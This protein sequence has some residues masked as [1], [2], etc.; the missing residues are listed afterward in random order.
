MA[1][2]RGEGER[3]EWWTAI[4][5]CTT[6]TCGTIKTEHKKEQ[7]GRESGRQGMK[8]GYIAVKRNVGFARIIPPEEWK[9]DRLERELLFDA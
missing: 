9:G 8:I 1:G 5:P 7:E 2:R 4:A 6:K 3:K